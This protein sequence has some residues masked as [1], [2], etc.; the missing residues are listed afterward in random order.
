M[1]TIGKI[2]IFFYFYSR[3]KKK[4][5]ELTYV[6]RALYWK[7]KINYIHTHVNTLILTSIQHT[8]KD[9]YMHQPVYFRTYQ[10]V[11][12]HSKAEEKI[13]WQHY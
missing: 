7:F 4:K 1:Y 8:Q 11:D 3:H 5:I 10:N 13:Y 2:C 6:L 12:N 9:E